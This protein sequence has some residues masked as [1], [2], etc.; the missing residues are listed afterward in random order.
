M[1]PPVWGYVTGWKEFAQGESVSY[2][3]SVFGV[4]QIHMNFEY[5]STNLF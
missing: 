2:N 5:D 3:G 1:H 4:L